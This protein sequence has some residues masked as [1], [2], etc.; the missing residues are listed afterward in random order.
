[1]KVE[2]NNM[3]NMLFIAMAILV[4]VMAGCKQETAKTPETKAVEPQTSTTPPA[5]PEAAKPEPTQ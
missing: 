2:G 5:A 1:V 4:L 3:K